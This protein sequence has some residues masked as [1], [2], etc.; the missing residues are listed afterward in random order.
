MRRLLDIAFTG[1]VSV[2]MYP[3]RSAVSIIAIVVVLVPY[4]VGVGLSRGLKVDA[5]DSIRYGADLYVRGS[6][7]GRPA[8]LPLSA[9]EPIRA[10]P[11]VERVV[12]RIVGEVFLGKERL[13]CVLVGMPPGT[14]PEWLTCIEGSLPEELGAHQ[15]VIGST[16]AHKL[17]LKVGARIPPFYRNDRHGERTSEIVGIFS[18]QAPLWQS[19]LIFTTF[20][21][22]SAIFE[23]EGLATD[24]LV[25]CNAQNLREISDEITRALSFPTTSGGM[26]RVETTT[27]EDVRVTLREGLLDREGI[28]TLQ[29]VLAFVVAILVLLV[30]SGLGLTERRREIGILKATGWQTDEILLRGFAESLALAL[31]GACAAFLLAWAWLRVLNAAGIA[32]IFIPGVSVV[33]EVPLPFKLTPVPLLLGFVLSIVVVLTGTMYSTWRAAIASPRDAMR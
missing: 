3:L 13:R 4:L 27:P 10:L 12:P 18:P 9:I 30:T 32:S 6:Q 14:F 5:E 33:P 11:G 25:T 15:L 2:R 23:Q 20:D 22:A 1:L 16:L 19:H 21:N 31:L 7:F 24:L 8:P 17:G 26:I 29:F 28:Y